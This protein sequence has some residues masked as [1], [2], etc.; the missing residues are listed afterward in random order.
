M[1]QWNFYRKFHERGMTLTKL[2]KLLGTTHS[3]C[4]QTISGTRGGDTRWKMV[5]FL[6]EEET[7][8]LGWSEKG[9]FVPRETLSQDENTTEPTK[10]K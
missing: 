7:T 2:A 1:K 4:S 6:T 9:T 5:Q 8:I 10:G 3:H